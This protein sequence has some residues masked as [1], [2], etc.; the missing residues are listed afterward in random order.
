MQVKYFRLVY[1]GIIFFNYL[2]IV[3][4]IWWNGKIWELNRFVPVHDHAKAIYSYLKKY[5]HVLVGIH[6]Y[7]FYKI[8]LIVEVVL[9][10]YW[11]VCLYLVETC[12]MKKRF[13]KFMINISHDYLRRFLL[14]IVLETCN[15]DLIAIRISIPLRI[16]KESET[17]LCLS[18]PIKKNLYPG[19]RY[20][21][22]P[23][24][25]SQTYQSE[26]LTMKRKSIKTDFRINGWNDFRSS[27][28]IA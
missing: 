2:I 22:S 27:N 11:P 7:F 12:K 26:F 8:I 13:S 21:K 28:E 16:V 24:P 25:N 9:R 10:I 1:M 6:R 14:N 18:P 5:L 20:G 17:F 3:G 19:W 15:H 4:P 23:L